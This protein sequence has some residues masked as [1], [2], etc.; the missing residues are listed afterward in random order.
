MLPIS[1]ANL[2]KHLR[3]S[4]EI[5]HI[6][7]RH[8][9]DWLLT[10]WDGGMAGAL[11][12]W[13]GR[14]QIEA[15]SGPEHVRLAL[16]ELGTTFIKLGQVLSTRPDLV[17][18]EYLA[19]LSKLQD[20]VRPAPYSQISAIIERELGHLPEQIFASFETSPQAVASIGQVHRARLT[21]GSP[22]VVKVQRPGVDAQVVQDLAMLSHLA[23]LLVKRDDWGD[24]YD[25]QG[26]VDEFSLAL[27][28][29]LDFTLEG[30]N[31]DR[32]RRNFTDDSAVH[33]PLVY[34]DYT[35]PRV[36]VL[37]EIQGIKISQLGAVEAAGLNRQAL[38]ATCARITLVQIFRHGFFQAD[39]HPGNFFIKSD[40][41]IGLIDFGQM[42]RLDAPL[43]EVLLRLMMAIAQH[44]ADRLVDELLALGTTRQRLNRNA[45]KRDLD[46][47][48]YRY[49]DRAPRD[50]SGAQLFAQVTTIALKHRLQLPAELTLLA[51]V[52]VM[53]EGLGS[54]LD[55]DFRLME[56]ARPYF[57]EFWLENLSPA[58]IARR[59]K[60]TSLDVAEISQ[61]LPRHLKRLLVQLE[62]GEIAF[63]G[64]L[65]ESRTVVKNLHRA[66]NRISLS[67]LIAGVIIGLSTVIHA[68]R[69]GSAQPSDE[70]N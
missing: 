40:G 13:M 17:P 1:Q 21:D 54:Y 10:G 3:R 46:H 52:V 65:E 19:E 28:D 34:W 16:E 47:V 38:A 33:I 24:A 18:P 42:G 32:M 36:L 55:P 20:N 12:R 70:E 5:A 66:A 26:W 45:L 57:E 60:D 61:D 11:R 30:R 43:R 4:R 22:V 14:M 56:F 69:P 23:A 51:K 68:Y 9:F 39:P 63:E 62:R 49:S 37:E 50:I 29:E 35:T 15:H 64:R 48:I 6:L 8:G 41:T 27:R 2:A 58:A 67:V 53:D 59:I 25:F 7:A 31:A 44:D